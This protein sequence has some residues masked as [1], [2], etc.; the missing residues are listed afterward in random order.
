MYNINI[1]IN[2][3]ERLD[4]IKI[5]IVLTGGGS[6]GHIFPLIS[7]YDELK[8]LSSQK[9]ISLD[10]LYIGPNGFGE[11]EFNKKQIKTK[12]IMA[13]KM[14]RYVSVLNLFDIFKVMIGFIQSL[15]TIWR[16]MPDI[17]FSKGGFGSVPVILVGW[18]YRIPIFIHESDSIP[19]VSNR[20]AAKFAKRIGLAFP[21][22][23]SY[24][25]SSKVAIVG[26]PVRTGLLSSSPREEAR[27]SFGFYNNWPLLLVLGGS[28]GAQKINDL[29]LNSLNDL[30]KNKVQIFH[31][32]GTLNE[33]QISAEAN[34]IL[35]GVPEEYKKMYKVAGFLNEKDYSNIL[36]ACDL[37]VARAGSGT[38]FDI[39]FAN[40][41]S[42]L[43]P[44]PNSAGGHQRKNAL[45]YQKVGAAT[46][47]EEKNILP[48]I[49]VQEILDIINDKELA[50]RLAKRANYFSQPY[51]AVK[52]ANEIFSIL[53]I[54]PVDVPEKDDSAPSPP[55]YSVSSL[56]ILR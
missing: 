37:V 50:E 10:A 56:G 21:Q 25:P 26:N 17:I 16:F 40:K 12:F 1:N 8:K 55:S 23:E 53:N 41:P 29:I 33:K 48:Q 24:F 32:V 54:D 42:I 39:S 11:K 3:V 7:V 2:M 38:I 6:G 4:E 43:I 22:A 19:G 35:H 44:L 30:I 27:E 52:I 36:S 49:L 45:E 18:L 14:R 46:V 47:L 9:L 20:I 15:I 34:I 31:Q 13:G 51:S 5:K 28:Q